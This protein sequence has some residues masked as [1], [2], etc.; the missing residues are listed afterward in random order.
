VC[1]NHTG[2]SIELFFLGLPTVTIFALSGDEEQ[3]VVFF[4]VIS[5]CENLRE[6]FG[7]V[8][9]PIPLLFGLE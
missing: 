6:L 1:G 7:G 2:T 8:F 4:G 9:T 5:L 3:G